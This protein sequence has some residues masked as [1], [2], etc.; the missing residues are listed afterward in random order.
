MLP[1]RW[2]SNTTY[3][4][5]DNNATAIFLRGEWMYLGEHYFD[6][7]NNI[8]QSPYNLLHMKAGFSTHKVE[9]TFWM[10][11]I[12]DKRFVDYAYDFGVVHNGNPR[13]FGGSVSFKF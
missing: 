11:N 4:I 9:C 5:S 3:S 1:R 10:R 12:T 7:A 8:R 6:Q 2:P 13:T